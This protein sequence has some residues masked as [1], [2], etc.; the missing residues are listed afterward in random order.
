M[1][2]AMTVIA[3]MFDAATHCVGCTQSQFG[4]T[5]RPNGLAVAKEHRPGGVPA[6]E[7]LFDPS[8]LIDSGGNEIHPLF[9]SDEWWEASDDRC[10]VL[11]CD[12]CHAPIVAAH[13]EHC[14]NQYG[15]EPCS[16]TDE[17]LP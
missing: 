1:T 2:H 10:E 11:S 17:Q 15:D 16:F 13:R 6:V 4:V 12:T 3:Y 7:R 8:E 14:V 9:A 5:F